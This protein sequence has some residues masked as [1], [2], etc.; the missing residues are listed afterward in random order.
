MRQLRPPRQTDSADG[1]TRYECDFAVLLQDDPKQ[2]TLANHIVDQVLSDRNPGFI[3]RNVYFS[4]ALIRSTICR[5]FRS[6]EIRRQRR[7]STCRL[8]WDWAK[9]KP[10]E[11]TWFVFE[12]QR[13]WTHVG[14]NHSRQLCH[15]VEFAREQIPHSLL[16]IAGPPASKNNFQFCLPLFP[17]QSAFSSEGG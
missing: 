8:S 9:R 11:H 1:R 2:T 13:P 4:P 14:H 17:R 3:S 16:A 7:D 5:G 12:S 15:C 6:T 10:R